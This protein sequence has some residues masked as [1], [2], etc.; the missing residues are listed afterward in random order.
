MLRRPKFTL[1]QEQKIIALHETGIAYKLIAVRW[2]TSADNI[3]EICKGR[4][5]VDITYT[6]ARSFNTILEAEAFIKGVEY[7]NDSALQVR[8]IQRWQSDSYNVLVMDT[9]AEL[10]KIKTIDKKFLM[11]EQDREDQARREHDDF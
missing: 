2:N 8:G 4:T 9:D 6:L 7:V 1:E 11:T 3:R 5:A 10:K